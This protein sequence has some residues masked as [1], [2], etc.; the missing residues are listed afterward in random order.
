MFVCPGVSAAISF[1]DV[2]TITTRARQF[3]ANRVLLGSGGLLLRNTNRVA[4][5][6]RRGGILRINEFVSICQD[7]GTVIFLFSPRVIINRVLS[8]GMLLNF[9]REK[10]QRNGIAYLIGMLTGN[11]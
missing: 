6:N 2:A 4:V 8:Q 7:M 9:C 11:H 5:T 1:T 3:V 10:I